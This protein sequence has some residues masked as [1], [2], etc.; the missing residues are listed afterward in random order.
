M[1]SFGKYTS[2]TSEDNFDKILRYFE[3]T[4]EYILFDED[5]ARI[6]KLSQTLQR[7][8]TLQHFA[9][10]SRKPKYHQ[11]ENRE[12]RT[13]KAKMEKIDLPNEIWLKIINNLSTKDVFQNFSLVCKRFNNLAL[14]PSALKSITIK[15]TSKMSFETF[16][17][18][19][20]VIQRSKKLQE[21]KLF[22]DKLFNPYAIFKICFE[23]CPQLK[24][25]NLTGNGWNS[26]ISSISDLQNN[27]EHL[28]SSADNKL[29]IYIPS[30]L[31]NLR[32]LTIGVLKNGRIDHRLAQ[33]CKKLEKVSICSLTQSAIAEFN[34]F[35][36]TSNNSLKSLTVENFVFDDPRVKAFDI[37]LENLESCENLQELSLDASYFESYDLLRAISQMTN[38]Q[39]L[40]LK[41]LGKLKK[42]EYW[43][44]FL[45]KC[46]ELRYL[47]FYDCPN[48]Q[49]EDKTISSLIEN[50]QQLTKLSLHWTMVS[51]ISKEI[52]FK[53]AMKSVNVFITIGKKTLTIQ[54]YMHYAPETFKM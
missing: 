29:G 5:Q 25:L 12:P 42:N 18:V 19:K 45:P 39:K 43:E 20:K 54:Q 40:E 36:D 50:C 48:I 22:E 11:V 1:K 38:L 27:I 41:N 6:S 46:K 30:K 44:H 53:A 35:L 51:K 52:W 4:V 37:F 34:L 13:K 15:N 32:T 14:D 28:K 31:P 16:G 2:D 7:I 49:L 24:T 21:L 10:T 8:S 23:A 26:G 47:K 3:T 9:V 33:K 17:N